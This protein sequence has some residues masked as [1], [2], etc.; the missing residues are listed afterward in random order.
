M[1]ANEDS[2][3]YSDDEYSNEDSVLS[4]VLDP[5]FR[6]LRMI[7]YYPCGRQVWTKLSV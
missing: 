7:V 1:K 4:K 3:E 6:Q 2:D 5:S